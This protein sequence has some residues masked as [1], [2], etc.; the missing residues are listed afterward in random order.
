MAFLDRRVHKQIS[1][2]LTYLAQTM[3]VLSTSC[4]VKSTDPANELLSLDTV[5]ENEIL[6][7]KQRF[8]QWTPPASMLNQARKQPE[9]KPQPQSQPVRPEIEINPKFKQLS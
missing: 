1:D 4:L 8:E 5:V 3:P 6:V 2:F 7:L 9:P